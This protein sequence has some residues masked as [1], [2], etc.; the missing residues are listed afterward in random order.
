MSHDAFLR[1][2]IDRPDDDT[3]RLVYADWLD[4]NGDPARAEFIRVQCE[5]ATLP[6]DD[7]RRPGLEDREHELLDANEGQW[8]G[9]WR[10]ESE[11]LAEW[12]WDR[13]FIGSVRG[14]GESI[15]EELFRLHPVIRFHAP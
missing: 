7:P 15:G 13:G 5:L 8:M 6:E 3:P 12:T 10:L 4:E 2:I 14:K 9:N 11:T 1:A